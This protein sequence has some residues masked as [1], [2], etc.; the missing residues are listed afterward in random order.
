VKL[1]RYN[2]RVLFWIVFTEL[3]FILSLAPQIKITWV[4]IWQTRRPEL[5]SYYSGIT[6]TL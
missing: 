3:P 1:K 4:Q 5:P 2:L 6:Y